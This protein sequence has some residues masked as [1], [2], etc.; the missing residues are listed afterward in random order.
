ML[1]FGT[2]GVGKKTLMKT[3]DDSQSLLLKKTTSRDEHF[4]WYDYIKKTEEL[5][6][7]GSLVNVRIWRQTT[8]ERGF[9]TGQMNQAVCALYMADVTQSISDVKQNLIKHQKQIVDTCRGDIISILVVN[10]SDIPLRKF[11]KNMGRDLA[12]TTGFQKYIEISAKTGT[13]SGKVMETIL[14]DVEK[15]A[16]WQRERR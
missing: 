1:L 8:Q 11:D 7:A 4:K 6:G 15:R 3:L 9:T 16:L 14:G 13:N 10:K 2:Q 12:R 5:P